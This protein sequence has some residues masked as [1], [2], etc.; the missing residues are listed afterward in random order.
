[1]LGK[2]FLTLFASSQ[3]FKMSSSIGIAASDS[4]RNIQISPV[5]NGGISGEA[6]DAGKLWS[7]RPAIIYVVRRPG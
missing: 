7:D 1:M 6:F 5:I 4:L 2:L 3:G